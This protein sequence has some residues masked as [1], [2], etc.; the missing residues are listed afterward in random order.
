MN[1]NELF[2]NIGKIVT[3]SLKHEEVLKG[4]M[5][6]IQRYF[7]PHNWSFLRF[8]QA[9]ELL[10][11][12]IVHGIDSELLKSYSIKKDEGIAGQVAFTRKSIFIPDV[13][14]DKRF[15]PRFDQ[16]TGFTTHSII[17]VPCIFRNEL[18]GVIEIIN[19]SHGRSFSEDDHLMLSTIADFSAIAL[20]NAAMYDQALEASMIDPLTG[21]FNV[22]KIQ[23]I[24]QHASTPMSRRNSDA[25]STITVLFI[26]LDNF[27]NI[28]DTYGH[29]TGDMVL[30]QTVKL[31]KQSIREHDHVIRIG[32]DEFIII[33]DNADERQND[34]IVN[35]I[36]TTLKTFDFS[37]HQLPHQKYSLGISRGNREEID[38]LIGRADKNMYQNK[39]NQN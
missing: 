35:R 11:F 4:I 15:D 24:I 17:A 18:Y 22:K 20:A 26:D 19:W 29:K 7:D 14:R 10:F 28:N 8:D 6:E 1:Q 5:D 32:G 9:S 39:H 37:S 2:A 36:V 16:A 34:E 30:Q 38:L 23:R 27:K 25:D 13:S 12:T 33:I 3:A 21:A 31:I